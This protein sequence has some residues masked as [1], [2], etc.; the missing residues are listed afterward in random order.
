MTAGWFAGPPSGPA[1]PGDRVQVGAPISGSTATDRSRFAAGLVAGTAVAAAGASHSRA[2]IHEAVGARIRSP[3]TSASHARRSAEWAYAG[4]RTPP[5]PNA[6]LPTAT[7]STTTITT[8][9]TP[10]SADQPPRNAFTTSRGRTSSRRSASSPDGALARGEPLIR[11]IDESEPRRRAR[12][13]LRCASDQ[14]GGVGPVQFS[15]Q[16]GGASSSIVCMGP[17]S[18]EYVTYRLLALLSES[19]RIAM[20]P[21]FGATVTGTSNG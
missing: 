5:K 2:P 19:K 1:L 17:P 9:P 18:I 10:G 8:D 4:P 14:A 15:A 6:R 7:R 13:A 16:V 20:P 3:G 21:Q 11:G 12:L